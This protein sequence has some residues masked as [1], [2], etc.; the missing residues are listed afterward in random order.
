MVAS[1]F[2]L[3]DKK[4]RRKDRK[5]GKPLLFPHHFL[6]REKKKEKSHAWLCSA[7]LPC[8]KRKN[9]YSAAAN[10]L[11]LLILIFLRPAA[12]AGRKAAAAGERRTSSLFSCSLA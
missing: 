3:Q 12:A 4:E 10:H 9:G 5:Q 6:W 7:L 1:F 2:P 11:L 8:M